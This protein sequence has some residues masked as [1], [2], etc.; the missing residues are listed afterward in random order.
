MALTAEQ[1]ERY[2]KRI[3]PA[4]A[5]GVV[6][7]TFVKGFVEKN[8]EKA[9]DEWR[10]LAQKGISAAAIPSYQRQIEALDRQLAELETK[11]AELDAK[12]AGEL[13]GLASGRDTNRLIA[14]LTAILSRHHLQVTDEGRDDEIFEQGSRTVREIR[15]KLQQQKLDDKLHFQAWRVEFLGRYGDVYAALREMAD[16]AVPLI[17]L[18]LTMKPPA[19]D[20]DPRMAWTLTLWI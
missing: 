20:S 3:L 17:P 8:T 4:L 16:N 5:I 13:G 11:K 15:D 10:Q 1:R 6:Y 14:E 2:L 9:E 18:D 19:D 12:L 7:F